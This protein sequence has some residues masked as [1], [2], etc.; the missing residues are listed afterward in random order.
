MGR[1]AG[2]VVDVRIRHK[3]RSVVCT[4]A[5]FDPCA[6]AK[7]HILV[8]TDAGKDVLLAEV[9]DIDLFDF[10]VKIVVQTAAGVNPRALHFVFCRL[11][12]GL[13][14]ERTGKQDGRGKRHRRYGSKNFTFVSYHFL[15]DSPFGLIDRVCLAAGG[16]APS[17]PGRRQNLPWSVT[18]SLNGI[19]C[20]LYCK[21]HT[22][23]NQRM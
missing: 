20:V 17:K 12:D 22:G 3:G 21:S 15:S 13:P 9:F 8:Q 23:G 5:V 2:R 6:L 1:P 4:A 18:T 7:L 11:A 19:F 14:R 10:A 16:T